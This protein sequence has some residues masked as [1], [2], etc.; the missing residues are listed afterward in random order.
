MLNTTSERASV[1]IAHQFLGQ[2]SRCPII[3]DGVEG[4]VFAGH[5]RI[6]D[7]HA[8]A[9]VDPLT[10]SSFHLSRQMSIFGVCQQM[11][12]FMVVFDV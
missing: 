12:H 4:G 1:L 7:D 3:G 11:A 6:G 10:I 8:V 9:F 2:S 5:N